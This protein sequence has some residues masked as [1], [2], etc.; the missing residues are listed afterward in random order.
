MAARVKACA[1]TQ[2]ALAPRP[3]AKPSGAIALGRAGASEPRP[4]FGF[5]K[6]QPAPV[7]RGVITDASGGHKLTIAP[8]GA[9]KGR[10]SIIPTLITYPG[11]V[12]VIDPKGENY[13]VT[14]RRRRAMGQ[15]VSLIDPFGVTGHQSDSFNPFD[16]AALVPDAPEDIGRTFTEMVT[17]GPSFARDPF[18]DNVA[19]AFISALITTAITDQP[20]Q[21]A[22]LSWIRDLFSESDLAYQLAVML[23]TKAVRNRDAYQ[24]IT[25]FLNHP[26]RETRPSVQ[27]TAAQHFRHFG[28]EAV[29]RATDTTTIPLEALQAGDPLTIYLVLPPDKLA[30]HRNLLRLWLSAML[31]LLMQ[32]RRIPRLPTL[33]LI[34]EAAQ[35]G[36]L[37][38]L[39]QAV[40]LMRGYGLMCWTFWQDAAQLKS[41]Y[42][43]EWPT[44]I[45]NCAT[46][47][48]FGAR[49]LKA[50]EEIAGLVGGIAPETILGLAPDEQVLLVPGQRPQLCRRL[51]YLHDPEHHGL[52]DPNPYHAHRSRRG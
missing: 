9:G 25:I 12:I 47:Q 2:A 19:G 6:A 49:N 30:S 38:L 26:E 29:R 5:G 48:L 16:L 20:P 40:T 37:E 14:A 42:P 35:L 21:N 34:D 43:Q 22:R 13:H 24:E 8:T 23:D 32:R 50:A 28:S 3:T 15:H 27:S 44:L 45:N 11:A 18:W 46:L 4:P 51:D 31:L 10:G 1:R 7:A 39:L 41:L 17:G 33:F 52:F 36:R